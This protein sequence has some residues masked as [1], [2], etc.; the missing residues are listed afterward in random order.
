MHP[1]HLVD[2]E[3][4]ELLWLWQAW[5]PTGL[6]GRGSLPFRGGTAEQPAIVMA[7]FR[8]MSRVAALAGEGRSQRQT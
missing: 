5:R 2:D 7:A 8:L 4:A 6:G 3:T 1:A